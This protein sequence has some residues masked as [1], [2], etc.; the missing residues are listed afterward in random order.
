MA[1]LPSRPDL[2]QLRR[3]A[4]ELRRAAA[5]GDAC[6]GARVRAVSDGV[7]LAA[8]QLALARE[9][10]FAS[11]PEMK[12]AVEER[13]PAAGLPVASGNH[14]RPAVNGAGALLAWARS[15]GWEPGP[16]PVGAVLT[17]QTFLTMYLED[18]PDRFRASP[19]LRPTNGRVFLTVAEPVVAVSCLGVGAPALVPTSSTSSPSGWA[20]LSPSDRRPLSPPLCGGAT[21]WWPR[22]RCGTRGSPSATSNRL[23]TLIPTMG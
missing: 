8:A 16:V 13:V 9:H 15:Q 17:S 14:G 4:K 11:W 10:G 1:E 18:Q 20:P 12:A 2:D 7:T 21:A 3:Q 6:A 5:G 23:L 22:P 19:E